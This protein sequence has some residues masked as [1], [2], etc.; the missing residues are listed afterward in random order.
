MKIRM[1]IQLIFG[2]TVVGLIILLGYVALSTSYNT[3][4]EQAGQSVE[5]SAI[6]AAN[7]IADKLKDYEDM[8]ASV[9]EDATLNGVFSKDT[10]LGV[11][12]HYVERYGFTSANL[13]DSEGVSVKDGTDFSDRE[14]VQKA[15]NGETN[16][17]DMTL[18]K[19]TG[20]YGISIAAPVGDDATTKGVLYFRIDNDFLDAIISNIKIS[21][22][23]YA[24]I[25]DGEGM[26]IS[27]KNVDLIQTY[28]ISDKSNGDLASIS[29]EIL[30]KDAGN[31]MY[32]Y[33]GN[34]VLCG[35]APIANT[36]GWTLVVA[37]PRTDFTASLDNML[38]KVFAID[39]ATIIFALFVSASLAGSIS[40][41][42]GK[43]EKALVAVSKG[44]FSVKLQKT[45]RRDEIGV[46]N[47]ATKELLDNLSGVIGDSKN[48]LESIANYRLD[49]DDMKAYSGDF[50]RI[51]E[52]I[53]AIRR[54]LSELI[55]NIQSSSKEVAV[56]SRE[57]ANA[58]TM[59]SSGSL[60]QSNSIQDA[61]T[62]IHN[63]NESIQNNT[64]NGTLVNKRLSNLDEE[65]KNGN[66]KMVQLKEVV[67]QAEQMSANIQKIV[68]A[69]DGIAFQ[70]NILALNASVEAARAGENGKGFAVVADEV[71]SL[72]EKSSQASKETAEL[73]KECITAIQTAREYADLTSES[74]SSIVK[75]SG[76]IAKAFSEMME[77]TVELS[78]N[79]VAVQ[80][81]IDAISDVVQS[82][83]ATAEE[84][85][86]A[87]TQLSEQ[88]QT[89]SNMIGRFR[90]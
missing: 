65:I 52:S 23:G 49:F 5:T 48:A 83:T 68:A 28:N 85:A 86:A 1:Q 36:N 45:E 22:N 57:L 15:L 76:E 29:D 12:E 81:E 73:I 46:L 80:R 58:A 39:I 13:L 34:N 90:I 19:Y 60:T 89:L 64:E 3:V 10:K 87:T 71:G 7:N 77:D 55:M 37:A 17:S 79:T 16:V 35:Y 6:L 70:T 53:N 50:N 32:Q 62:S 74:L 8:T 88:A 11:L 59:L 66:E 84:T 82:N 30:S 4:S 27:H 25:V 42:L 44:D 67:T 72:A 31:A 43:V 40:R 2:L 56:G 69:I 38:K 26:I 75:D 33:E 51:S 78:G 47:N 21:E 61:V 18:S 9:G 24:Y 54:I 63:M 14:Y 20:K 41:P